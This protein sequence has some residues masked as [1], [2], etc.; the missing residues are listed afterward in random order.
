VQKI[1]YFHQN[2]VEKGYCGNSIAIFVANVFFP[3]F[4]EYFPAKKIKKLVEQKH[5]FSLAIFLY[6]CHVLASC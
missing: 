1:H 3:I 5:C 6:S 4:K 2:H